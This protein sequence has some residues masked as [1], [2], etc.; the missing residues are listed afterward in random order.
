MFKKKNIIVS[1]FFLCVIGLLSACSDNGEDTDANSENFPDGPIKRI[2]ICSAGGGTDT[3][4]RVLQP[5]VEEEL[6]EDVSVENIEGGAGW[7]GWNELANSDSDGYTIGYAN[8]PHIITGYLNPELERDKDLD[9]FTA[10]GMHVIDPDTVSIRED[11]DRFTDMEELIEYAQE[12]EVTATSTGEGTD[13]HLVILNMNKKYDT[14]FKPVQ[15]DGASETH[16]AVL[17]EH[18]DVLIGNLGEILPLE[19]DHKINVLGIAASERSDFLPDTPT[20]EENGY[21]IYQES[22]RGLI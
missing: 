10:L 2:V 13:E 5:Y 9:D 17:G 1:L 19:N 18:V 3:G 21:D 12:H 8:S 14:N 22:S 4:A 11:E 6:G 20:L 16:S 7:V 15:F